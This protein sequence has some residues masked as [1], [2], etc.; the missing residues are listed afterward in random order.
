MG[1]KPRQILREWLA[2]ALLLVAL[3]AGLGASAAYALIVLVAHSPLIEHVGTPF[4][5]PLL[6]WSTVLL[7]GVVGLLAG[8]FPARTAARLD[9]ITALRRG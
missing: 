6:A 1:A 3:G 2:Q 7:L 9:P 5:P 4:V 8:Y